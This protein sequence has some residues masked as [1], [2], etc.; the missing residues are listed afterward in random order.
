MKQSHPTHKMFFLDI[1][2]TFAILFIIYH[3]LKVKPA[4][5]K[6]NP[7]LVQVSLATQRDM[8]YSL[9]ANGTVEAIQSVNVTPQ[10]TGI[11]K[12]MAFQ[13]G[14]HV[15]KGQLLF[16][17]DPTPY[18]LSV[19]QARAN[20]QR[21]QAQFLQNQA[22]A[23]RYQALVKLEYITRQQYEQTQT[24]LKA[25]SAVVAADLA[26]LKQYE[27]QLSYTRITAP[28]AGKTGNVTFKVGDLITANNTAP[29]VTINPLNPIWIDFNLS[30][31]DFAELLHY[32]KNKSLS[33]NALTEDGQHILKQG[34]LTFYDNTI[35]PQSGTVLLKAQF[36]NEDHLLWPG[37]SIPVQII[38]TIEHH[39]I[40][41]PSIA[42]QADQQ[43]LF[44]YTIEQGKAKAQRITVAYQVGDLSVI[45]AGLTDKTLVITTLPPNFYEGTNVIYHGYQQ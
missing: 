33:V 30:Q 17:I 8:P 18:S 25:Q 37:L 35:N 41:I 32:Q 22:D 13:P 45:K 27:T 28:V 12:Q 44:V 20:L 1:V 31:R 38:L 36:N 43:G 26:Q 39:A 23:K 7:L 4:T 11:L 42:V 24:A 14:A 9:S 34:Q 3:G 10:V 19:Q 16:I 29:L 2:C 15:N 21:D 5:K 40:V 6:N